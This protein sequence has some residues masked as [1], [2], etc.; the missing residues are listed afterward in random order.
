L[1][2]KL[3]TST[4]SS[5]LRVRDRVVAI[6][7]DRT[8]SP[9]GEQALNEDAIASRLVDEVPYVQVV[10]PHLGGLGVVSNEREVSISTV[11]EDARAVVRDRGEE[12]H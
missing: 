3:T 7:V 4:K 11:T 2:I 12:A 8:S 6:I 1:C 5:T 9:D 10:P